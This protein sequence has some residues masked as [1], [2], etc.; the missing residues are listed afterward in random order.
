M[1]CA[2]RL[3]SCS[4]IARYL[5]AQPGMLLALHTWTRTLDLHPHIHVLVS[6][7]GLSEGVWVRP[8]RS[9]FLPA[10]VL[11]MLFRGKFLAGLRSVH[12]RG[13]LRRPRR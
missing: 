4:P 10:R 8:R 6:D 13:E 12:E 2:T 5:G 9:H 7:G 1:R 3:P 11:M